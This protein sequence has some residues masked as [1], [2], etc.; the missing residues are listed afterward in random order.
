M[1]SLV[2]NRFSKCLP[3][4]LKLNSSQGYFKV[5]HRDMSGSLDIFS[6]REQ[7]KSSLRKCG[8]AYKIEGRGILI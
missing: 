5:Y 1:C 6:T 4:I 7:I 8:I 3:F 2:L